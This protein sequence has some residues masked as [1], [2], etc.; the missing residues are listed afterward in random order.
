MLNLKKAAAVMAAVVIAGFSASAA[1]V[2]VK[3]NG[4]GTSEYMSFNSGSPIVH[5]DTLFVPARA[6]ADS[7]GMNVSWDQTTQTAIFSVDVRYGADTPLKAYCTEMINKVSVYNLAVT[8]KTVSIALTA[9]DT[10][11]VLRFIFE[12][13]D[14]S[15]IAV[16]KNVALSVAPEVVN[17]STLMIPLRE[18]VAALGLQV[19]W[20][21]ED[22]A[23]EIS[24]PEHAVAPVG[25]K[26]IP[27]HTSKPVYQA[28]VT[29][30]APAVTYEEVVEEA[31]VE[32]NK[33]TYLG[34]FKITHY[35]PCSQCNGSW[36]N[37]TA[38]ADEIKPGQTI[39]V[40]PKV[41]AP[42]SWV[43]V[44]GYGLRRAEDCGGAVKGNH[45]DMAIRYHGDAYEVV[46][47][48]VWLQN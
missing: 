34:R 8:P 25:L 17:D 37:H 15:D 29:Y 24:I 39:A 33:G 21:Q 47:R 11:A 18:A 3:M 6:L 19:G 4:V 48:D 46:Y 43:Y 16:G 10:N 7:A 12:D 26:I 27:V 5:N 45:I 28:P 35:C 13:S 32:E 36:G 38:Y 41:I 42:L 23:V 31:P 40:D 20:S 22:L 2:T 30:E 9:G 1:D 44:D 14:A